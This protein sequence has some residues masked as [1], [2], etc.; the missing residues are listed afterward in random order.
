MMQKFSRRLPVQTQVGPS[1]NWKTLPIYQEM[2]TCFESGKN[3]V[4]KDGWA[5]PF[6]NCAQGSVGL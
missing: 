6:I 4:A 3:K 5:L 2:G 1:S